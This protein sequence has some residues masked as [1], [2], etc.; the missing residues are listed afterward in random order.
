MTV[1]PR[2]IIKIVGFINLF[3]KNVRKSPMKI[4]NAPK[5]KLY[6]SRKVHR[7][8]IETTS[9]PETDGRVI[10]RVQPV[11]AA[12]TVIVGTSLPD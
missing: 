8:L 12:P 1:A 7:A 2:P 5:T 6:V 9:H 11:Y 4:I 3:P 10:Y